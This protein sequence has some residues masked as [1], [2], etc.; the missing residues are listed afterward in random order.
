[1]TIE[2]PRRPYRA[3]AMAFT[4]AFAAMLLYALGNRALVFH[5]DAYETWQVARALADPS[6]VYRSFVEYRGF[7][8]F[9]LDAVIYRLSMVLGTDGVLT[10][11]F[12]SSLL[13]AAF[14][15]MS[16]PTALGRL[17][18][19]VPTPGKRLLC[20]AIVFVFFRGYFLYPSNDTV[21]LFF[22]LLSLNAVSGTARL[23]VG[24]TALAGLW[25]GGAILSRSNYVVASPFVF[26]LAMMRDNAL[27]A[28][29]RWRDIGRG[30]ALLVALGAMFVLN[31]E[32][33][34]HRERA[35]RGDH[36]DALRV[37]SHQLA[38][39]L[40]IQRIEWNAGDE[41][42][43]GMLVYGESRGKAI[44]A[45]EGL[46]AGRFQWN[47]Y[48]SIVSR[49]PLDV[50]VIY[51]RHLFNGLDP[52]YPTVYVQVVRERSLLFSAL[53]FF[54][55]FSSLAALWRNRVPLR[56]TPALLA[57]A[58]PALA[59]MPFPVESRF[60]MSLS[61]FLLA[62]P[63]FANPWAKCRCWSKFGLA[64]AAMLFV[65][66]CLAMSAHVFS[67]LEGVVLP[68]HTLP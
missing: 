13:F 57:M 25:L 4:A 22:L 7:V 37:L 61:V 63:V 44:L 15:S 40:R 60:Y 47:E 10:F 67:S 39:G 49:H 27:V 38:D 28:A 30:L 41:R 1:M 52:A 65:A 66:A 16:L 36:P 45:A 33:V 29:D 42:Y 12:F 50:G 31:A 55:M 59:C 18:G 5:G 20:A 56:G 32:Y 54:L 34:S 62:F 53:N 11:R 35:D 26:W 24:R 64:L 58:L 17:A 19:V 21:A 43:P 6:Y 9:V 51:A 3:C 8:V 14:S 68:F 48:L 2:E 23:A 46:Q